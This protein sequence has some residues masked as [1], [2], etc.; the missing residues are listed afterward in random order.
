MAYLEPFKRKIKK[1]YGDIAKTNLLKMFEVQFKRNKK[2]IITSK[3][4]G[5]PRTFK[6]FMMNIIQRIIAVDKTS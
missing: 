1:N 4:K 2:Y 3:G 5:Y 6:R